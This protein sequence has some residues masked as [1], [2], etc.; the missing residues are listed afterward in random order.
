MSP[1]VN[2]RSFICSVTSSG[3]SC[4]RWCEVFKSKLF[5]HWSAGILGGESVGDLLQNTF[6]IAWILLEYM[7][8]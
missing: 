6:Y 8:Q 7:D 4:K 3:Q 1:V 2:W 5:G